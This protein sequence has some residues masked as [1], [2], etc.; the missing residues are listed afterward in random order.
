[1]LPLGTVVNDDYAEDLLKDEKYSFLYELEVNEDVDMKIF[2]ETDYSPL[3]SNVQIQVKQ[4]D[5]EYFRLK[6]LNYNTDLGP[7][8]PIATFDSENN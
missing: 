5:N 3:G 1:M 7:D 2:E 6:S 4:Y 8:E